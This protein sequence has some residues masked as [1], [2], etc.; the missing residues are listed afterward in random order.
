MEQRPWKSNRF[1]ASQEIPPLYGKQNFNTAF[2]GASQLSLSWA[3]N[4][5]STQVG[6]TRLYFVTWYVFTVRS[7]SH[8]T[9]PLSWNTTPCWLCAT[10]YSIY[11]QLPSILEA[12]P[13]SA[14]WGRAML[15]W[16][17]PTY[18]GYT[19]YCDGFI[20]TN[21]SEDVLCNKQYCFLSSWYGSFLGSSGKVTYHASNSHWKF[22]VLKAL[23]LSV[24]LKDMYNSCFQVYGIY[25]H[26]KTP[27]YN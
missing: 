16:Q 15:W 27:D 4:S 18:L 24:G 13:H 23:Q 22:C 5:G 2:T 3:H 20:V 14:T 8:L 12:V 6:G 11:L 17:T 9:Q 26:V 1:S 21:D 10:A 19:A 7:F 25:M